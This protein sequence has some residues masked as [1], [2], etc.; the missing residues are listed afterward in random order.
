MFYTIYK[1]TNLLDNK[2]YIGKHQTKDLNDD[3]MGS[4]KQLKYAIKKHGS[5][6]FKK[7][8]L[9]IF[10]NEDE[11][12]V[13]EAE[14]VTE[15]FVLE[16]TNYNLCPGGKGG[17]G[18]VNS[19]GLNRTEWHS[20]NIKEHMLKIS[21]LGLKK[22]KELRDNENW[23]SEWIRKLSIATKNH[24]EIN[25]H[26]FSGKKHTDETKGKMSKSMSGKSTG[27]KHSQ[28]NTMWI[29]S[30]IEKRSMKIIK[31][32]VIPDGW[33]KGRKIKF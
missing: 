25:G 18:Y 28:Y 3:Y 15:E 32:D 16:D 23:K 8:I 12:N 17:W 29:Y 6:N 33:Y 4:G 7:E 20:E 31:G 19:E 13:K 26:P 9:F 24:I 11:M 10:D 30:L 1:I 22:Q 14:L 21:S 27:D 5:E 2:I